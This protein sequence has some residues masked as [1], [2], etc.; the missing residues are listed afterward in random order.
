MLV[1]SSVVSS[2]TEVVV[3]G[4]DSKAENRGFSKRTLG[5]SCT[6][7]RSQDDKKFLLLSQCDRKQMYFWQKEVMELVRN[8]LQTRH[9]L[10]ACNTVL[11]ESRV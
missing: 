5:F 6:H 11:D 3:H 1:R 7:F 9:E 2:I 4:Q 10:I 8:A